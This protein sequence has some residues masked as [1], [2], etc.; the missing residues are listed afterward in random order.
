MSA[1]L[2]VV[3]VILP[4]SPTHVILA[5]GARDGYAG[6]SV[7]PPFV[8]RP[9]VRRPPFARPS[10][11]LASGPSCAGPSCARPSYAIASPELSCLADGFRATA[12]HPADSPV[13]SGGVTEHPAA[14]DPHDR[15]G[16]GRRLPAGQGGL[17]AAGCP[18]PDGHLGVHRAAAEPPGVCAATAV[19]ATPGPGGHRRHRLGRAGLRRAGRRLRL[20]ADQRDLSFRRAAPGVRGQCAERHRMARSPGAPVSRPGVGAAERA[21]ASELRAVTRQARPGRGQGRADPGGRAGDH[22]RARPALAPGGPQD[23]RRD[24]RPDVGR[25]GPPGIRGSPGT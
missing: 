8:R 23:A 6:T 5:S 12:G 15:R 14:H 9:F 22:L 1:P 24:P 21:Q 19:R 2:P 18:A 16:R 3:S 10:S 13:E 4:M 11:P 20:P 17:P 25:A 7:R